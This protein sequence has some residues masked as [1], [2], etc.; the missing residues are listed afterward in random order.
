[1]EKSGLVLPMHLSRLQPAEQIDASV[2]EPPILGARERNE[3]VGAAASIA[4]SFGSGC[5]AI[6][7]AGEALAQHR[8]IHE[9]T[10]H[11]D[12]LSLAHFSQQPRVPVGR[13]D[14]SGFGGIG[15]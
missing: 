8:S 14:L 3:R 11:Q 1:M 2:F 13:I 5:T 12:N 10:T 7:N 9:H 6:R 15:T 4:S